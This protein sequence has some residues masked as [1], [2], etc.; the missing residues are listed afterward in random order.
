MPGKEEID[1]TIEGIERLID[2]TSVEIIRLHADMLPEDQ[3]RVFRPNGK[4]KIIVSTNIAE[5]SVTVPGVRHV[6]D[7]GYIKQIEF[8][9]ETGIEQLVLRPH[10]LS[11][12]EQR[13]GRAGRV[14]PG[15]CYR[16]FLKIVLEK[17]SN[18]KSPKY[19]DLN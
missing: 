16:L 19:K 13:K 8:D 1:R 2:P 4:R 10:A 9:P 17:D 3:D 15:R 7:S 12:L 14:A 11:G 18:I 6:V 5:T